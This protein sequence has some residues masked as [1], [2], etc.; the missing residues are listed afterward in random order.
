M[1]TSLNK[2]THYCNPLRTS[3]AIA[4]LLRFLVD[5]EPSRSQACAKGLLVRVP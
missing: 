3:I 4:S 1:S 2:W 5:C